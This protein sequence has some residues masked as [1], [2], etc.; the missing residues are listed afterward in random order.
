MHDVIETFYICKGSGLMKR[1]ILIAVVLVAV[2]IT[3]VWV[4]AE[5]SNSYSEPQEALLAN[6]K[7]LL[8][9]PAYKLNNK[10]LFFFI[11]NENNLGAVYVSKG[12]FGWKSNMLTWSPMD[13]TRN[14]DG[15]T[16]NGHQGHGENLLYGLIKN[17][18]N[19]IVKVNNELAN[20]L[21]LAMLSQDEIE[22]FRLED[23]YIWYFE[24]KKALSDSEIELFDKDTDEE[25][26]EANS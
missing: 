1:K 25:L 23:L 24:S 22:S 21:D 7:D 10:A 20:I 6:D 4:M 12:F 13:S 9:I 19:R 15:D 18:D 2:I 17:G 5:K 3:G 26:D 14:Y 16:L 11:K 8:L